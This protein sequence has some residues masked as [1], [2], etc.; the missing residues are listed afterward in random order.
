MCMAIYYINIMYRSIYHSKSDIKGSNFG[1]DSYTCSLKDV[2]DM[3][4]YLLH[5][6]T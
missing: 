6:H 4:I 2:V 1:T 3:I 5:I